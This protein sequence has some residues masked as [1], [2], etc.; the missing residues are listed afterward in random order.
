A[1][2]CPLTDTLAPGGIDPARPALAVKIGNEPGDDPAAGAGARPQSGLNEAD[3]VYDTP[4]EGFI[5]RYIAVFQCQDASSIGPIRS[6]RWVDWHIVRQFVHPILAFVGGINPDVDVVLH[7]GWIEPADLLAGQSSAASQLASREPPDAT[8][9][10]TGALYGLYKKATTPPRPVFQYGTSLNSRFKHVSSV[11]IDFSE[12]TDVEWQWDASKNLWMHYYLDGGPP[13][14]DIDQL[15][16]D[17]VSTSNIIIQIVKYKFGP[18][19]ESPGSTGD[20]ESNTIGTGQGWLLRNGEAIGITWH[21][22][23]YLDGLTLTDGAG[24]PIDLTPGRTW[25]ELLP[26]TTADHPGNVVF[27]PSLNAPARPST[28]S[29]ST[30]TTH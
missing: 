3:I 23:H 16:G 22:A 13:T 17:Q 15:T 1:S 2:M 18:Y 11:Q 24:Q 5:M 6:V 26:D 9:S 25:V 19:A 20:F 14:A 4:A 10:S 27:T 29:S 12:G 7:S 30:S 28:S 8:Y 21:R